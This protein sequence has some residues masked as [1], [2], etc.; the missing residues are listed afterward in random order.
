MP[1]NSSVRQLTGAQN[2]NRDWHG[3][4]DNHRTLRSLDGSRDRRN[5]CPVLQESFLGTAYGKRRN[6]S[7]IRCLLLQISETSMSKSE[8]LPLSAASPLKVSSRA[9]SDNSFKQTRVPRAT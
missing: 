1:L 5:R 3:T 8:A 6:R 2:L 4:A 7:G 9:L